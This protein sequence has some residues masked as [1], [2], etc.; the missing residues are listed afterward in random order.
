[1]DNMYCNQCLLCGWMVMD[2]VQT[3]IFEAGHHRATFGP[4]QPGGIH[5]FSWLSRKMLSIL[6]TYSPHHID[7]AYLKLSIF[8]YL[9]QIADVT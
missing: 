6:S 3:L 8:C 1:M 7:I 4:M 9:F 2:G 5:C